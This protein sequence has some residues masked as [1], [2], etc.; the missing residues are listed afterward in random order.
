MRADDRLRLE[1][2]E[3]DQAL[4]GV[5][6]ANRKRRHSSTSQGETPSAPYEGVD[7]PSTV[8]YET[9]EISSITSYE[10]GDRDFNDDTTSLNAQKFGYANQRISER[11]NSRVESLDYVGTNLIL[12]AATVMNSQLTVNPRLLEEIDQNRTPPPVIDIRDTLK[13]AAQESKCSKSEFFD[14]SY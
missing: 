6:K 3:I 10:P 7:I 9:D 12:H 1:V 14:Y 8:S 4:F 13:R 11:G 5:P 2:S